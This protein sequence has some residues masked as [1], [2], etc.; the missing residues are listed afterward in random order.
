M[1]SREGY[2]GVLSIG[3]NELIVAAEGRTQG[4]STPLRSGRD[5]R[6]FVAIK[7]VAIKR[8]CLRRFAPTSALLSVRRFRSTSSE[9]GSCPQSAL[10]ARAPNRARPRNRRTWPAPAPEFELPEWP[11]PTR[12][13]TTSDDCS[14]DA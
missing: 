13:A 2:L 11:G 7:F 3:R 14:C 6:V 1:S 9:S 10:S 5:D 8:T 12:P 4:P